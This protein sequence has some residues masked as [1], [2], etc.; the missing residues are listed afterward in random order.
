[1]REQIIRGLHFDH[2]GVKSTQK[3][4]ANQYYWPSMK[5]DIKLFVNKCD[6]CKKVKPGK[7]VIG[8]GDFRVP[9]KRF[10]HVMVDIVGPLPNSYGY[11]FLLTAI[12]RSTRNL[13]AIPLKE[14]SSQEAAD[15]FLHH[16][17]AIW[18]LPALVTSAGIAPRRES[19]K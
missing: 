8:M 3:R 2:L 18:G 10:S 7:K 11:R 6:S 1:M 15:A 4:V 16:W 13:Q 14:A 17:A 9:D 12:C 5:T 19:K